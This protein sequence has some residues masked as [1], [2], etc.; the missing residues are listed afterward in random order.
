M[1]SRTAMG[2]IV[3][4]ASRVGT[5]ALAAVSGL[6]VEGFAIEFAVTPEGILPAEAVASLALVSVPGP[7]FDPDAGAEAGF[8]GE[9]FAGLAVAFDVGVLAVEPCAEVGV[10]LGTAD[11]G[12]AT[13]FVGGTGFGVC[14]C[15]AAEPAVEA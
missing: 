2:L 12:L 9:A 1:V 13:E 11:A 7:A 14:A 3:G 4:T 8:A 5:F 15:F 10:E 6:E